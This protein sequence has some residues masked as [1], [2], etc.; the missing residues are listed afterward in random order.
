MG[1]TSCGQGMT[2]SSNIFTHSA[3]TCG[4]NAANG[5]AGSLFVNA[6]SV[7]GGGDLHLNGVVAVDDVTPTSSDYMLSTTRMETRGPTVRPV[8]PGRTRGP[9]GK[10]AAFCSPGKGRHRRSPPRGTVSA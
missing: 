1:Q 8:T 6:A 2:Y 5:T 4:T 10:A 9:A 3:P 7:G